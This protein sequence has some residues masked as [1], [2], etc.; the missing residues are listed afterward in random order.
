MITDDMEV[1]PMSAISSIALLKSS[2]LGMFSC[3]LPL[4]IATKLVSHKDDMGGSLVKLYKSIENLSDIPQPATNKYE[5][6]LKPT[7]LFAGANV[8][9]FDHRWSKGPP[10][11]SVVQPVAGM[12]QTTLSFLS[13]VQR[14]YSPTRCIL[15]SQKEIGNV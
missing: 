14:N 9:D 4:G 2:M 7:T 10:N 8:S 5:A 3:L 11:S 12:S 6:L 15:L 13:T 1:K